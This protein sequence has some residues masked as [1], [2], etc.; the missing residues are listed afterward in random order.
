MSP[1]K[2]DGG[3]FVT[4]RENAVVQAFTLMASISPRERGSIAPAALRSQVA[5]P[6][7]SSDGLPG[8]DGR[9]A[10][11]LLADAVGPTP[12]RGHGIWLDP[13]GSIYLAQPGKLICVLTAAGLAS[14]L[15]GQPR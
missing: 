2:P 13:A 4:D 10:D 3:V 12:L 1:W 8:L 6:T 7:P 15:L 11:H 5:S 9:R 14:V